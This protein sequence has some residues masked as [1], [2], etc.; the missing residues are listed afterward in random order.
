MSP[1]ARRAGLVIIAS[2]WLLTLIVAFLMHRGGD[3]GRLPALSLTFITGLAR[4]PLIGGAGLAAS[5]LGLAMAGLIVLAWYGLGDLIARR[6]PGGRGAAGNPDLAVELAS[7][8]LYGAA[9]WSAMWFVLGIAG[10]YRPAVAV[11]ALA[12]GAGLA[13]LAYRRRS[14]SRGTPDRFGAAGRVALVLA[15]VVQALALIAALAP[16]T[17]RDALFYHFAIPKAYVGAGASVIVPDNMATFYPQGV[18]MQVVWALLLGPLCGGRAAEAAAG[19]TVFV[20]FPLL[21]LV[22]YGWARE[23]NV[24]ATWAVIATAMIAAIPTAYDVAGSGY[25]DHALAA[26]SALAV[27]G[28]ARWWA[29]QDRAFVLPIA[30]ALGGALSIKLTAAFLLTPLAVLVLVRGLMAMR[31]TRDPGLA[32][33]AGIMATGAAALVLAVLFAAPW[34]ARTWFR[35]G[36]PVYPFYA[37]LW[38][39]TA[40]GWDTERSSLYQRLLSLYGDPTP[41]GY[42]L[43]P[44]RLAVSA[45]P[46]QPAR[47]DG[48]LGMAFL[49]ALPLV[50]WALC[51]GWL[52]TELCVAL[53]V[54]AVMFITWLGS[55]QQIRFLLPSLPAL[56]VATAAA[57]ATA[58]AHR[59]GRLWRWAFL[60]AA[61]AGGLVI[62]AWFAEMN[63]VRAVL[64][65]EPRAT[66]LARRLD[67]Y[68]YYEAINRDLPATARVWLINMRRDTYH[69]D[70]PHF[71]DFVFEDYSLTRYVRAAKSA[72]EIRARMRAAGITHLLVRHDQLFDYARSPIVDDR[73][74][75]EHNLAKLQLMAAFF[76]E[77]TRLIRGDGKFWLIELP[78][79][80]G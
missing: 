9:A 17:A 74:S 11:A 8:G 40:P 72:E 69:L 50:L 29:T 64:G 73:Q 32:A 77:D 46:D 43:A 67:Y 14:P 57:G 51:H 21:L 56:A 65:G 33:A 59:P 38:A 3:V 54:S 35:T 5:A 28:F 24:D 68:P 44:I 79:Q 45:Q 47:Y 53:F 1:G 48:V 19:A 39:G 26:Y 22:V 37:S 41:L 71:S 16:P 27:R 63:P 55:S 7:R 49:L 13:A 6:V 52:D 25:V 80:A 15:G 2:A 42:L 23:R 18:E 20:F 12:V 70:R 62:L 66:Y 4:A 75:R 34:P 30:L 60:A 78:R 31:D 36:S 61:A 76:Q 10:L 58:G